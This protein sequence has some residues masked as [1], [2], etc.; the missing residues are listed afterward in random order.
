[1]SD[2]LLRTVTGGI[3]TEDC[4]QRWR[5][6]KGITG[7][8]PKRPGDCIPHSGVWGNVLE[9]YFIVSTGENPLDADRAEALKSKG[10]E[11]F[12]RL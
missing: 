2:Y 3:S 6:I 4:E 10:Y 12:Q 7:V 8:E 5:D 9:Y 11:V 1:M